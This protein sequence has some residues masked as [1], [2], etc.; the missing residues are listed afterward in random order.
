MHKPLISTI[1]VLF[2]ASVMVGCKGGGSGAEVMAT[3]NGETIS[4]DDYISHLERK[5]QVLVQSQTGPVQAQV[6]QPLNFQALNDLVNQRLLLQ[7]AKQEGVLP[8]DTDVTNEMMFQTSKRQ[9]FIL[10]LTGQGLT[11]MDIKND[12]KLSLARHKLLSKGVTISDA[13]VD[14][15]IKKNPKQFENP[16]LVDITWVV[17]KNAADKAKVDN[18]LKTGQTFAI[19]ART[20]TVATSGAQYPSRE[21]DKFPARMKEV[22]DKLAEN[23]TSD[24]LQDKDSFVKIHVEKK[25]PSSKLDIKPWMKIE[26]QRLLAEQKGSAAMDLDKRLLNV[27]KAATVVITKPGLKERFEQLSKSLKEADMKN[28]TSGGPKAPG[29]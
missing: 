6:A 27:R 5:I 28:A 13:Q 21:F 19:V 22:V 16:K 14:E 17:L 15:F 4:K 9:D 18:D 25:T 8:T 7:M 12:L 29:K 23:G 26:I 10:A 1:S 20:Y 2:L 24:W 11:T 3:V